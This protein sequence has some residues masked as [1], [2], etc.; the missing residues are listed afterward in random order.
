MDTNRINLLLSKLYERLSDKNSLTAIDIDLMLDY[1]RVI[2]ADLLELKKE[3]YPPEPKK[4]AVP[5][6]PAAE[7]GEVE[8]NVKESGGIFIE[9][10][11]AKK[12]IIHTEDGIT[13]EEIIEE[14]AGNT[15]QNAAPQPETEDGEIYNANEKVENTGPEHPVAGASQATAGEPVQPPDLPKAKK[16]IRTLIGI[17]DRYLFMN[18][19][20]HNNKFDYE[21]V[22]D[23]INQSNGKDAVEKWLK[24]EYLDNKKWDR[25]DSTV[26]LFYGTVYK[27]FSNFR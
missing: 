17:N 7:A 13:E 19:L 21:S 27:Y 1:T 9:I 4:N 5:L 15:I 22:L 8:Q 3:G 24:K 26:D 16:D 10:P 6:F 14:P 20:F 23:Y 18:E 11:K 25:Q 12:D 2:Y